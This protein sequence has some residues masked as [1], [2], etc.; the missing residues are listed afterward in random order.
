MRI[1]ALSIGS[2]EQTK[3][4]RVCCFLILQVLSSSDGSVFPDYL[5]IILNHVYS[6]L[7]RPYATKVLCFPKFERVCE[8]Q[9]RF[10]VGFFLYSE[11]S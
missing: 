3:Y 2:H 11:N 5:D 10:I 4:N 6:A 9:F 8:L 7:V 1:G